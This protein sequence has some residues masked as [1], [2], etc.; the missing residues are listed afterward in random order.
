MKTP[1]EEFIFYES[2]N[3]FQTLFRYLPEVQRK[4][5]KKNWDAVCCEQGYQYL[6]DGCF[7]GSSP[8]QKKFITVYI[9]VYFILT[10]KLRF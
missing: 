10:V 5:K 9:T 6:T 2:Y 3:R 8:I 1:M 4:K 7:R